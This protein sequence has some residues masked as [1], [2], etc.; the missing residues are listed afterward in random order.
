[1]SVVENEKSVCYK[2]PDRETYLR[3]NRCEKLI[4]SE[5]AVKTPTGY[6]CKECVRGQQKIFD[7]AKTQDFVFGVLT[8]AILGYLGGLVSGFIGFFVIF[9]APAIGVGIAEAVRKIIQKRRSLLLFRVVT[10]A[11]VAGALLNALPSLIALFLGSFNLFG[12]IWTGVYV[13]L[14]ASSL[15]YRL[16]GIQIRR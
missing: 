14:M 4:C 12:L 13:V 16:S 5:C 10:G 1:M 8:A 9:I 6:R 11:A 7:T 3:C 15:F 2:H